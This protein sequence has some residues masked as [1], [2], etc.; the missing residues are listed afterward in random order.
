VRLTF[1][2]DVEAFRAEFV[3]FLSAHL[4]PEAE[5]AERPRSVSHMPQWARRWQRLLFDNGW[6]LPGN[7][8]EFGGRNATILQQYVHLEEL[9]RRRIYHSLNPQGVNIVAASLLSFGST[10]QKHRWA[11]PI[12]RAEITASLGMSEPGA[13]SDLASLRTRATLDGD[14]FVV[15]GQKVWTSGAH[16][17][18]VLLTFVR[19]DPDAAKH[20]GISVLLIPTDTPGVVRRPFPSV[21]GR[22]DV[23]FNEVFFNDVRVPAEN[24][25]GPLN[26]GWRVAT[27][28]LGHERT[29]MWLGFADRLRNLIADFHPSTS[30]DRDRYAT[31]IM[32]FQ[33]LH[34][35]GSA[36]LARAARGEQ[37]SPKNLAAISVLKLLGSEAEQS[38]S[39]YILAA[40]GADGLLHPATTAPYA[41]MNLDQLG[42]SWFE[43]YVRSFAGTI[44]GGTS[45]IQRN[46]IAQRILGLPQS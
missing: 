15:N 17:A 33:A 6:L 5:A 41:H 46:I 10:E 12:L 24:L 35:L 44:A 13:G 39:E 36:A 37:D 34:L 42:A 32:D 7:P 9:S 3:A 8:P 4:P 45:E 23:D 20:K 16:D 11:V 43:R 31:L 26:Q 40:A 27:G 22:E 18:D 1:D 25:V 29:M 21:L 2:A 28:S 38:A 30:V 14:H 19:T